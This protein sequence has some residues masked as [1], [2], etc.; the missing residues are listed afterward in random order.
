MS[1]LTRITRI[2]T[3]PLVVVAALLWQG[4]VDCAWAQ[5]AAAPAR[6]PAAP[7]CDRDAFRVI[8]DVGHTADAP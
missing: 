2:G 7:A 6:K 4:A 5:P 1:C 3:V 8:V